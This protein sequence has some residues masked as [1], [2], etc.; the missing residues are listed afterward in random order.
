[1]INTCDENKIIQIDKIDNTEI[2]DEEHNKLCLICMDIKGEIILCSK[3]KYIYCP[4]CAEKINKLC[5]ICF[6]NKNMTN[7]NQNYYYYYDYY[8]YYDELVFEPSTPHYFS[9]MASF[10]VSAIIGLYWIIL[11]F[12]FG[13][14]GVI[15][16]LRIII[17]L[18]YFS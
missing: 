16:I 13:Y 8:S 4:T 11:F 9:V 5:S 7:S 2:I 6:R 3:C 14:I 12:I 17:N 15:F 10:V 1:M 18:I